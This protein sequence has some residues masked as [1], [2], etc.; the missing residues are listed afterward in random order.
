[1]MKA[2]SFFAF[3]LVG[4]SVLLAMMTGGGGMSSTQ[5]NDATGI[6]ASDTTIV[7]DDAAGF[8]NTGIICMGDEQIY[9]SSKTGTTQFN[10]PAGGRGYNGTKAT[11][12][13]DNTWVRTE[14][15]AALNTAYGF[16]I[17]QLFDSWGLLAFPIIVVKFFTTT[18]PLM[19]QGN[20][21]GI[22]Q[23]QLSILVDFWLVFGSGFVF[24]LIMTLIS[25]RKN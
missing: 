7:V 12:H 6:S 10:I 18:L 13:S 11:I 4:T 20:I 3:M 17:G 21:G 8:G 23:G 22:F 24:L 16:N 2:F 14:D 9:Y 1:M 19:V 15:N 5:L 25:A